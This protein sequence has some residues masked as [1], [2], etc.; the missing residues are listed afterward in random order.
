MTYADGIGSILFRYKSKPMKAEVIIRSRR[1]ALLYV[2]RCYCYRPS[3]VVCPSVCWS[4]TIVSPAETAEA[5]E[6]PFALRTRVGPS[7]YVLDRVQIPM[8]RGNFEGERGKPLQSI[9]ALC[10]YLCKNG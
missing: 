9:G 6:M 5:I 3:S 7:M 8:E 10:G 1:I 4:V 2:R